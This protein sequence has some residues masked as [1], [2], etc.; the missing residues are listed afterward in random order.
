MWNTVRIFISSTF[1]DMDVER[2]ALKT[3]F[4]PSSTIISPPC[5][6]R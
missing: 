1:K 5:A 4:C 6:T 2:D 3:S